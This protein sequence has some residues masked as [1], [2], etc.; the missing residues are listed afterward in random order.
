[1]S[2]TLKTIVLTMKYFLKNINY[3]IG[4]KD[5]L[6]TY[7]V[8]EKKIRPQNKK[9]DRHLYY[10]KFEYKLFKEKIAFLKSKP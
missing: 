8:K 9:D 2:L 7:E 6:H 3:T 10:K 1:M 4:L 5:F